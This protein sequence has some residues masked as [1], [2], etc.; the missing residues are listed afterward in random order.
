MVVLDCS[1]WV[2]LLWLGLIL[3][4]MFYCTGCGAFFLHN[5]I[6]LLVVLDFCGF[7]G[8]GQ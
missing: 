7:D 4:M 8:V 6:R 5:G 2:G 1:C 3:V